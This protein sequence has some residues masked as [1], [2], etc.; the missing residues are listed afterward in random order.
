VRVD[1]RFPGTPVVVELLGYRFHRSMDQMRRD[2]ER[3]NALVADG[4]EP[5]QFAYEHVVNEP[6]TV[7][8]VTAAALHRAGR[9]LGR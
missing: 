4:F 2:A 7:L 8:A 1:I 5:Y 9:R 3:M 6:D